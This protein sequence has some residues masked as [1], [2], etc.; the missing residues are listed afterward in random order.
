MIPEMLLFEWL[1]IKCILWGDPLN[2]LCCLLSQEDR[3]GAAEA[4][5]V[6]KRP[7]LPMAK[8]PTLLPKDMEPPWKMM[9]NWN[10]HMQMRYEVPMHNCGELLK[11]DCL[12]LKRMKQPHQLTHQ[13]D[14]LLS[15][16]SP[17]KDSESQVRPRL[18]NK[19]HPLHEL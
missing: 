5:A 15:Y 4:P 2:D 13:L 9:V 8:K 10:E 1:G 18:L 19:L 12:S 7:E 16:L 14:E 6:L 11:Q 3:A 17:D